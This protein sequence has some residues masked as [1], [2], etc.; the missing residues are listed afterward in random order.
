MNSPAPAFVPKR[1]KLLTRP[2]LKL[3]KEQPRYVLLQAR[4]YIGKEMRQ[5]SPDDKKKEPAH[6][7]DV[8]D[9]T[10]GELAQVIINAVP[11][12]VL[13]EEYPNFGYVGRCFELTRQTRQEG[14]S[15]DPFKVEEIEVPDN[16]KE[17][18]AIAVKE[19]TARKEAEAKAA[20]EAEAKAAEGK[21]SS[22]K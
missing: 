22:K 5:R 10:T 13:T 2:V 6:L 12:S 20:K 17:L 19:E 7:V 9:L 1:K 4:I 21:A 14:K 15:Y 16:F 11:M 18:A 3:V 8:I